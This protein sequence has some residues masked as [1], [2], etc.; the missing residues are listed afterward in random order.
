MPAATAK[1]GA[2]VHPPKGAQPQDIGDGRDDV[3]RG[4]V[5]SVGPPLPLPRRLDEQGHRGHLGD[6]VAADRTAVLYAHIEPD[7]V[8]GRHN[9]QR[10]LQE[11][12]ALEAV[13]EVADLAIDKPDL[14]QMAL[15]VLVREEDIVKAERTGQAAVP[16]IRVAP[17]FA[18]GGQKIPW[19]VR[20]DL[21][22]EDQPRASHGPDRT[23]HG[24]EAG[25]T[26]GEK[27]R[28]RAG[29][30]QERVRADQ[31]RANTREGLTRRHPVAVR[32]QQGE[33][34]AWMIAEGRPQP[35]PGSTAVENRG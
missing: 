23:H 34:V 8:I 14:Q 20:E 17:V 10:A 19:L 31:R 1:R 13:E 26:I 32:R 15:L 6:V 24:L 3:E 27:E 33:Q 30:A 29:P 9:H 25:Y 28:R 5:G 12:H 7:A 4:H 16:W 21:M 2:T 35:G 18:P 11:V 22:M